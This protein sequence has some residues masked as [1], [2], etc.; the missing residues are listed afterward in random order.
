MRSELIPKCKALS[1]ST[2]S[3]VKGGTVTFMPREESKFVFVELKIEESSLK[4]IS[5]RGMFKST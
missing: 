5:G 3:S 2:S 1:S 4:T